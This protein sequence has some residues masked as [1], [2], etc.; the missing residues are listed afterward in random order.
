MKKDGFTVS[1]AELLRTSLGQRLIPVVDRVR[2][3]ATV[4]GTRPYRVRIVRTRFAGPRRGVGV[5]SVVHQMDILPTPKV[6]DMTTLTELVTP[7]G[8]NEQGTIQLQEVSGR[9]TEEQLMGVGPNGDA[10]AS[11]EAVYFEVEFFRRDGSPSELR[12]FQRDSIPFYDAGRVQWIVTL[13]SVVENR[14]RSGQTEG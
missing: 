14:A 5:E 9:Y 11:N 2:D 4:L 12:R 6:V 13:V 1:T 3:I 7:V 10:I 8:V